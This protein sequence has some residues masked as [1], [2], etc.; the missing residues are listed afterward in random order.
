MALPLVLAH[1]HIGLQPPAWLLGRLPVLLLAQLFG[2]W[3]MM[4]STTPPTRLKGAL[5]QAPDLAHYLYL[6]HC[7]AA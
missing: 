1:D 4:H 5:T 6:T 7:M 3:L 2:V